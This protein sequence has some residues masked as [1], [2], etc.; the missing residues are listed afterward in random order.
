M[1][2][3]RIRMISNSP[4]NS[5]MWVSFPRCKTPRFDCYISSILLPRWIIHYINERIDYRY[6]WNIHSFMMVC[7]IYEPLGRGIWWNWPYNRIRHQCDQQVRTLWLF[8]R[9]IIITNRFLYFDSTPLICHFPMFVSH[10]IVVHITAP[11][12]CL[13]LLQS[14]NNYNYNL[15]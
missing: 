9:T 14:D 13:L 10:P 4:F 15:I 2:K 7:S 3:Y 11:Y 8:F 5:C 6:V 12:R 1:K